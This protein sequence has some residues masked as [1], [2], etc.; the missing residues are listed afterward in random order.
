MA[1]QFYVSGPAY[2]WAGTGTAN[3]W[4][5][6]GYSRSGLTVQITPE[7]EDI[8]VDYA[9]RTP[10]DV[11]F[12]GQT[13]R[14]SGSFT[15]YDEAIMTKMVSYIAGSTPGQGGSNSLGSLLNTEGNAYPLLVYSPYSF[16]TQYGAMVPGFWFYSTYLADPYDVTLN[17][18]AKAP[19]IGW[20]A[21]PVFGTISSGTFTANS[22]PFNA[23]ELYTNTM[24]ASMPLTT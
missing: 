22:A 16:K 11:A 3:A 4:E 8:E 18:R 1:T 17:I 20:R 7:F 19:N 10:G 13:A 24:P 2:T 14:V 5:F 6:V 23:Y 21:I 15:R 12:L 9:G